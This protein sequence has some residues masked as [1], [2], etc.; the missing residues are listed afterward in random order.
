MTNRA[1]P[2][3]LSRRAMRSL[4]VHWLPAEADCLPPPGTGCRDAWP[5]SL[6]APRRR[7]DQ[8][9]GGGS[10]HPQSSR[11]QYTGSLPWCQPGLYFLI[12]LSSDLLTLLLA[13]G[14]MGWLCSLLGV[15]WGAR[16]FLPRL[17]PFFS[18]S[19]RDPFLAR[20]VG[21]EV[22]VPPALALGSASRQRDGLQSA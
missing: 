15:P 18:L 6:L 17:T 11:S 1:S 20:G 13:A 9:T 10:S 19:P 7:S 8:F 12:F 14:R 3:G 5:G 2:S 4:L 21:G 22:P 16:R